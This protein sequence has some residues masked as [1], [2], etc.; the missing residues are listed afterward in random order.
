M[1]IGRFL[2]LTVRITPIHYAVWSNWIC[3][4]TTV[5]LE[6]EERNTKHQHGSRLDNEDNSTAI[7]IEPVGG[8]ELHIYTHTHNLPKGIE[9]YY[10]SIHQQCWNFH[11]STVISSTSAE[12]GKNCNVS[13]A[14]P[15]TKAVYKP[16]CCCHRAW[17]SL[18]PTGR[19][20]Y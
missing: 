3:I 6:R 13:Q 12:L 14:N 10:Y 17:C 4:V 8:G 20:T 1:C 16:A 19:Q 15:S 5:H 18:Q 7:V 2:C 11:H 9:T